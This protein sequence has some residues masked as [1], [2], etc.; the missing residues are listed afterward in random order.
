[1]AWDYQEQAGQLKDSLQSIEGNKRMAELQI[2]YETE[3]KER[4]I[5]Q[6]AKA[7]AQSQL[8]LEVKANQLL[9]SIAGAIVAVLVLIVLY[10]RYRASQQKKMAVKESEMSALKEKQQQELLH[11]VIHTQEAEREKLAADLHD[12]LGQMLTAAKMNLNNSLQQL[13]DENGEARNNIQ[14]SLKRVIEALD[15]SKSLASGLLPLNMRDKGLVNGIN[16]ICDRNN[17]LQQGLT[18]QFFSSDIPSGLP[19]I[20]EI[21]VYRICQ[22]LITN[23]IKHAKA[24]TANLQLFYR[25]QSLVIQM[26]DNGTGINQPGVSGNGLG[27]KNI[28]S[29]VQLLSGEMNIDTG[30]GK[31]TTFIIHIPVKIA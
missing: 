1:V 27:L 26:E 6:M 8:Q 13:P 25:D 4:E 23:V 3:K 14:S 24:S 29:R 20:V 12:G 2:K 16:E 19:A 5:Q 28:R 31:G 21:N 22:E 11:T 15:E 7:N 18:I 17:N 9:L 30:K 10:T